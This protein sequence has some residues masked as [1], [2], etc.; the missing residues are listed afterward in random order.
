MCSRD[1]K[2]PWIDLNT[3]MRGQRRVLLRHG[4]RPYQLSITRRGRLILT[5][6]DQDTDT[7]AA[8]APPGKAR[9]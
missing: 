6:A 1:L 5:A 7:A 4:E 8:A 9:S 3:L 2:T